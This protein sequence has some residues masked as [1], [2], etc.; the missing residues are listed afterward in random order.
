MCNRCVWLDVKEELSL[1]PNDV[2]VEIEDRA[3]NGFDL[4]HKQ[5][6]YRLAL[7]VGK[8][9]WHVP[10]AEYEYPLNVAFYLTVHVVPSPLHRPP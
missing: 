5:P 8:Y 10:S 7:G 4:S 6:I 3:L 2:R 9:R 1:S